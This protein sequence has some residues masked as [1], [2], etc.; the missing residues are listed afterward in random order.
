[1]SHRMHLRNQMVHV[2]EN[3]RMTEVQGLEGPPESS[4]SHPL[5]KQVPSQRSTKKEKV[6]PCTG[7]LLLCASLDQNNSVVREFA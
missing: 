4:T 5:L 2:P 1:M 7:M 6:R 3:D